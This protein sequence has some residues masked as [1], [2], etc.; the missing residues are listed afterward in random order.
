MSEM[1]DGG[2]GIVYFW[3]FLIGYFGLCILFP[4]CALLRFLVRVMDKI[5]M[6]CR[7]RW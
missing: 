6:G 4:D 2:N 5:F 1:F 3:A 7:Q